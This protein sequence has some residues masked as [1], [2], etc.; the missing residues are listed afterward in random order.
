M[1]RRGRRHKHLLDVL[2]ESSRCFKLKEGALDG[3]VWRTGWGR[4]CGTV[5]G[6]AV[7]VAVITLSIAARNCV[8]LSGTCSYRC[9]FVC[10][11]VALVF[12]ETSA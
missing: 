5:V 3:T 2:K 6:K 11:V 9:H 10:C 4:D 7:Y 12:M 8:N 1:G